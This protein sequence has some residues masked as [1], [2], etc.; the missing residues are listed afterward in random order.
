MAIAK[1]ENDNLGMWVVDLCQNLYEL[2][3]SVCWY[4][5]YEWRAAARHSYS[6]VTVYLFSH[7]FQFFIYLLHALGGK[8]IYK[9]E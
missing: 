3:I 8:R 9:D 1:F 6:Y 2:P 4:I 5:E 7:F